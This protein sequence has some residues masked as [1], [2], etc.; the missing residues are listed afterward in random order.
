M[1]ADARARAE[2]KKERSGCGPRESGTLADHFS[3]AV[4]K[5]GYAVTRRRLYP[6]HACGQTV[7]LAEKRAARRQ[8]V[9]P[10]GRAAAAAAAAV[11]AAVAA[12]AAVAEKS[13][14]R[15]KNPTRTTI[16]AAREGGGNERDEGENGCPA[17]RAHCVHPA[18]N[19]RRCSSDWRIFAR[20]GRHCW[21]FQIVFLAAA[22]AAAAAA[23]VDA[24]TK[25][26]CP[27]AASYTAYLRRPSLPF[28][29][30]PAL[31]SLLRPF[32]RFRSLAVRYLRFFFR[33]RHVHGRLR[34]AA[35]GRCG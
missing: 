29:F 14:G 13:R 22:V 16:A 23:G 19:A 32:P 21:I 35:C 17:N 20:I 34:V 2:E 1:T 24:K 11:A 5:S 3:T 30:S 6:P 28:P 7:V 31:A 33:A 12:V 15:C 25:I 27:S 9:R 10:Y 18:D 8:K 26:A 4:C